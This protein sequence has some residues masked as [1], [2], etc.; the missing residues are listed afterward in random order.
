MKKLILS[1]LACSFAGF[2][3][4][5]VD[6]ATAE[7]FVT[8]LTADPSGDY[9][10][11]ADIDLTGSGFTTLETFSGT[12]DGGGHTISGMGAQSF[13]L[14]NSGT[15]ASLTFDGTVAGANTEY[16][17]SNTG[18]ICDC[19][20]GT[21]S[22]V[23]LK[24]YTVK[25][26]GADLS[27]VALLAGT[28]LTG[29]EF[30][31]CQI[32]S[33]CVVSGGTRHQI[34]H[35]GYVGRALV[36]QGEILFEGC[37][38]EVTFAGSPNYSNSI[39]SGGFVA[40]VSGS[41]PLGDGSPMIRFSKCCSRTS[42]TL[43]AYSGFGG[44]I[45][46]HNPTSTAAANVLSAQF[47][48]CVC[49]SIPT[50]STG[51][52]RESA[53][54]IAYVGGGEGIRAYLG[55]NRCVNR[56]D[57]A[58]STAAGFIGYHKHGQVPSG[59]SSSEKYT[60]CANYGN[61]T[62]TTVAGFVGSLSA[63]SAY[64]KNGFVEIFNCANYGTLAGTTAGEFGGNL[65]N[66]ICIENSFALTDTYCGAASRTTSYNAMQWPGKPGYSAGNA[67]L[68]L[69]AV[70]QEHGWLSWCIGPTGH[71]EFGEDVIVSHVVEFRDWDGSLI[72]STEVADGNAPTPPEDPIRIGYFFM[73]WGPGSVLD[74]VFE[75]TVFIAQYERKDLSVISN[76]VDFV[77]AMYYDPTAVYT[78]SEDIDCTGLGYT[79]DVSF[80]GRLNGGGH[81]I[82]GL[83]SV[84]FATNFSGVISGVVFD[85]LVNS[86]VTTVKR[87]EGGVVCDVA[88]GG[89]FA[90]VVVRNYTVSHTTGEGAHGA[91]LF[92][93]V[94]KDG[95]SFLRCATESS[96][97]AN[98]GVA[99]NVTGGFAGRVDT[100][101]SGVASFTD[102]TN[103]ASVKFIGQ[104]QNLACAAGGFVG[105]FTSRGRLEFLRCAN[106]GRVYASSG[107]YAILGGFV[108]QVGDGD[109]ASSGDLVI[110]DCVNEGVVEVTGSGS[111][112]NAGGFVGKHNGCASAGFV[113]CANRGAVSVAAASVGGFVGSAGVIVGGYQDSR[114]DGIRFLDC[115]NYAAVSGTSAGGFCGP[116]VIDWHRHGW[117]CATNCANYA[118]VVGNSNSGEIVSE[119][120]IEASSGVANSNVD[121]VNCLT[122]SGTLYASTS[123]THTV[124][125]N[126]AASDDGYTPGAAKRSLNAVASEGGFGRW[127][128]GRP[129]DDK[130]VHPELVSLCRRPL[131]GLAIIFR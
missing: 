46:Q 108:G 131:T 106:A 49:E 113:R 52:L 41:G 104:Y 123:R 44:F 48:D 80:S 32:A 95:T 19:V 98:Q 88:V 45:G 91:G 24:G 43:T 11:T 66:C 51:S 1:L 112:T 17:C 36:D 84:C 31:R 64:I 87:F 6:I 22:D 122:V 72:A 63:Y 85:G 28:A 114:K 73:G 121:I 37:T 54:F 94:V 71:P 47:D 89:V 20:S 14:T 75:D 130:V 96:C 61:M 67:A 103:S 110:T 3:T 90:D 115:A 57:I 125:D 65:D 107:G 119:V 15:I 82:R 100:S 62:G 99:H 55:F 68:A 2:E 40:I 83:G 18:L 102:C 78:L 56:A 50:V 86:S 111:G 70:A 116:F 27:Y 128:L 97:Q 12:L 16:V 25:C 39:L 93:G 92:A 29:A 120:N 34:K 35:G 7:Q 42:G 53:G 109:N 126:V 118:V 101:A 77:E 9:A 59:Y 23:L 10:L 58:A 105:K 79:G 127:C 33:S 129:F 13:C 30:I 74:P 8:A 76:G 124:S 60:D 5:A 38:N 69:T 26:N 117:L 81:V 21:F 4:E